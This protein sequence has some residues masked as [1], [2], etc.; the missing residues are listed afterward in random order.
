M[1]YLIRRIRNRTQGQSRIQA[2]GNSKKESDV[3][4]EVVGESFE[5]TGDSRPA[6]L[7]GNNLA[8]LQNWGEYP[9]AELD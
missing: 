4:Q 2:Y 5:V 8:E 6:E 9:S 1:A 7:K 3:S